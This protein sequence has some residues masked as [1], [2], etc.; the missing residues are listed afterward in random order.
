MKELEQEHASVDTR[1]AAFQAQIERRDREIE[2]LGRIVEDA[3]PSELMSADTR[4]VSAERQIAQLE[5]QV[6]FLQQSNK[7]LQDELVAATH[8]SEEVSLQFAD[9]QAKNATLAKELDNLD[10]LA[11]ELQNEK[12]STEAEVNREVRKVCLVVEERGRGGHEGVGGGACS[13]LFDL[14]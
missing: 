8:H 3:K 9:M 2:R 1:I 6:E 11:R 10:R 12:L 13:N 7:A 5:H 14:I 4:R